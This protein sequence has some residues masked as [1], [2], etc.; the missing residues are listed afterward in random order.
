MQYDVKRLIDIIVLKI[1]ELIKKTEQI[2]S[3]N[4]EISQYE[5]IIKQIK[6]NPFVIGDEIFE[7]QIEQL[8]KNIEDQELLENV[9]KKVNIIKIIVSA[10][11]NGII[12]G[13]LKE[14]EKEAIEFLVETLNKAKENTVQKQ[15][16]QKKVILTNEELRLKYSSVYDKIML[17]E[18]GIDPITFQEI[19][20]INSLVQNQDFEFRKQT[21]YYINLLDLKIRVNKKN[22]EF[23]KEKTELENEREID[24][25][26]LKNIIEKYGFEYETMPENFKSDLRKKCQIKNLLE[27]LEVIDKNNEFNFLKNYGKNGNKSS[28]KLK[29]EFKVLCSIF[30]DA[31]KDNLQYLVSSSR[32]RNIDMQNIFNIEGVYKKVSKDE[33]KEKITSGG[34]TT[35][36]NDDDLTINGCFEYYKENEKTLDELSREYQ[37]KYQDETIDLFKSTVISCPTVI[38]SKASRIKRNIQVAQKY[39]MDLVEKNGE[40]YSLKSPTALISLEFQKNLDILIEH[41]PLDEYTLRY[42]T[43]LVNEAFMFRVLE[44]YFNKTLKYTVDGKIKELRQEKISKYSKPHIDRSFIEDIEKNIPTKFIE[45]SLQSDKIIINYDNPTIKNLDENLPTEERGLC[46]D[47]DGVCVSKQKFQRVWT[48]LMNEYDKLSY[49]EKQNIN[50]NDLMIY[51]LSFRS[52]YTKDEFERLQG[53]SNGFKIKQGESL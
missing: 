48:A 26:I 13:E 46:Y 51:A 27:I 1:N 22:N 35:Q 39:G 32:N 42:P 7:E 24:D 34:Q 41:P 16:Q 5:N 53:F 45:A 11:K 6:E 50:L 8:L 25:D 44:N 47:I 43:I 49:M 14:D 40:T 17:G 3:D 33:P 38:K 2:N 20:T 37:M 10:A 4:Y 28:R 36:P 12:I 29:R 23:E 31:T 30:I 15:E 52:Y 21:L 19:D 18:N 9:I